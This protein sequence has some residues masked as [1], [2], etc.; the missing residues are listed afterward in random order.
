MN[1][2]VIGTKSAHI[3][4]MVKR[5]LGEAAHMSGEGK[6]IAESFGIHPNTVTRLKDAEGVG[7]AKKD[8]DKEIHNK[9]IES[10]VGMFDTSVAAHKLAALE[11]KDATRAMK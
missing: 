11:T 3:P 6:A 8:L 9:A 4:P 7:E 2:R 1:G 5:M 10:I